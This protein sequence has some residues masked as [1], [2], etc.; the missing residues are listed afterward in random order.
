MAIVLGGAVSLG[1]AVVAAVVWLVRFNLVS[2]RHKKR[3]VLIRR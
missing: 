3:L 1:L 2:F